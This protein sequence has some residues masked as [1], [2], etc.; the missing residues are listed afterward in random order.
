MTW[1]DRGEKEK[2]SV[3]SDLL[4]ILQSMS[5]FTFRVLDAIM[6]VDPPA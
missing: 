5:C 2:Y 3:M 1:L 4:F 6:R